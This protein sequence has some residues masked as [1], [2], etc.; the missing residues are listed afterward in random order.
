MQKRSL[1]TKSQFRVKRN[2]VLMIRILNPKFPTQ[3]VKLQLNMILNWRKRKKN[4][5]ALI[6]LV[7]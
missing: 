4:L 2:N 3:I 7:A 1:K 6:N 5:L